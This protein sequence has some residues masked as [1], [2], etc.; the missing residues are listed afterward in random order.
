[1]ICYVMA[2]IAPL[3]PRHNR[4][5]HPLAH[6]QPKMQAILEQDDIIALVADGESDDDELLSAF[7]YAES[8]NLDK[9]AQ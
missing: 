4:S 6:R 8:T 3:D 2:C 5:L 9:V 7:E 1:M